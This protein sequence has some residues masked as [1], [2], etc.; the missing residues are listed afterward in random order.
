M[1]KL[2]N[3]LPKYRKHK[4]SGQAVV[5]INRRD[6]YLGPHGTKASKREYDR[7][8]VE[9]LSSGRSSSFGAPQSDFTIVE[10][11]AE[12]LRYAKTYYGTRKTSEYYRLLPI[13][14][15]LRDLYGR[16]PAED[17]GP[18]QFKSLRQ[19]CLELDWSRSYTNTNMRRVIRMFRWAAAEGKI[20]PTVPQSLAI[21]PGLRRGKTDARETE[22]VG[23]VDDA[24]VD[25]TLVFLPDVVA[26][27]V[28]LQRLTGARPA[29]VCILRP[30]DVHHIGDVWQ[31]R[32]ASHKTQHH[33]RERVIMIG[34]KAQGLL[35]K[36][37]PATAR[38]TVSGHATRRPR[39]WQSAT[40]IAKRH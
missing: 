8:V 40:P 31:Y 14:R 9:F 10:L 11:A 12:Y 4:A 16:S 22:P 34:P 13:I 1:P 18:L 26:D 6:H 5:T 2:I 39:D 36:Y 27:M 38:R 7:L 25:A 24:V 20:S 37:S 23:P 32:P 19:R 35:L 15:P 3:S 17:F 30:C 33:G 21:V 28:R 29:E